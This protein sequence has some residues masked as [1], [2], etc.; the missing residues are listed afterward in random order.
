MCPC[1]PLVPLL[2]GGTL[3]L[4]EVDIDRW[5]CLDASHEENGNIWHSVRSFAEPNN[6]KQYVAQSLCKAPSLCE[7]LHGEG[8]RLGQYE[9]CAPVL[10]PRP[11]FVF[12]WNVL[13]P[14]TLWGPCPG[15]K[16]G[17]SP[18]WVTKDQLRSS[19]RRS[20]GIRKSS[21]S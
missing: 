3:S 4:G 8:A 19:L 1:I 13:G 18:S 6:K 10:A 14:G 16:D 7:T 5:M 9:L 11:H 20:V 12:Q 17:L 2:K 15:P 21:D